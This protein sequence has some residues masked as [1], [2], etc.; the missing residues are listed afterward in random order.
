[1]TVDSSAVELLLIIKASCVN[2]KTAHILKTFLFLQNIS[3]C[4]CP[5]SSIVKCPFMSWPNVQSKHF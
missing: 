3:D 5:K 2:T 1:M 4:E